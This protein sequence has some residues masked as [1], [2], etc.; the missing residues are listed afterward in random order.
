V[1]RTE[2]VERL[3]AGDVQ[4][5][6]SVVAPAGYGKTTLLSQW[7]ERESRPFAWV[8]VDDRD[9]DTKVLLAYVAAALDRV[10]PVG[11]KV[12][13]ALN[14]PM[15]SVPGSVVPRLGAA[16]AAMT[17][18]VVLVLD[19]VHL[20]LSSECRAALSVLAEEVPSGSRIVL[21]GRTAPPV[22]IARLRAEGRIAEVGPADLSM[23]VDEAAALL[24][25][26][27]VAVGADDVASLN[28]QSEGWPV[29][30]YLA[31]LSLRE[32]GSVGGG[33]VSF[34]GDDRL[35]TEYVESEFLSYVSARD[36]AFLTRSAALERMSGA[37]CEAAL[38]LPDAA[39]TLA[40]VAAS[41]V[42]LVPLDRRGQWYRYHHL[43]GDT[44]RAELE[45]R[46][47]EVLSAVRRRAASWC[48][49]NDEPVEAVEYSIAASD[50][51][52]VAQLIEKFGF[53]VYWHGQRDRLDR[54]I[55]WL[56]DREAI[57]AHPMVAVIAGFLCL[58]TVREPE[59]EQWAG[60]LDQ[61]QY[62]ES[63]WAADPVTEAQTA[64]LR[65][66]VCR[67]GVERMRADVAEATE[68]FA[69]VG[70][71]PPNL[72]VYHALVCLLMGEVDRG[73][74]AFE[75]AISASEGNDMQEILVC[76]LFERS[77]VAMAR[78]DWS[79]A[80]EFADRLRAACTRPGVEEV[81]VWV[82]QARVAA[83]RGDVTAAREALVRAQ[84]LRPLMP[85][86]V[87]LVQIRVELAR[88][89]LAVNDVAGARTVLE[90]ADEVLNRVPDL[91]V[92][93]N[94]VAALR[95]RLAGADDSADDGPSALTAA[96]MR[97]LPMLC[98]H[99]TVPE[100]AAQMYLSRHTIRSQM[101]SIYR[102]LEV[103][104]RGDAVTRARELL[105]LG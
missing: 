36:R 43:F 17:S 26:A 53:E 42:L 101:Q 85:M 35:V 71:E 68:K 34:S 80:E 14:S 100:I 8:S 38:D 58:S 48:L 32:R 94:D 55:R 12:F 73:D 103:N 83:H 77:L 56:D 63:G 51:E 41:N 37:L 18:P 45:R 95:S 76:A 67:H 31:A 23:N 49:A 39:A 20:L 25:G 97:L 65:A 33:A 82:V 46:E 1:P 81:F 104:S 57:K 9:N 6:V 52:T 62:E 78:G 102:K 22:R 21:A 4:S 89:Y 7:A 24:R 88:A 90:E 61:W 10:E 84:P 28:E 91:G 96:E 2:L 70:I 69:A 29:G 66:S 30:L 19:D 87:F 15:S 79:K 99:L 54:W 64:M 93:V 40:H 3:S 27:D 50:A 105:L 44:L 60:R 47:P 13:D 11:E 72:V 16:L 98:T 59:A 92:L 75:E 5:V 86:P 74:A